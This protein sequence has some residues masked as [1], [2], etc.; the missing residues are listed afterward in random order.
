MR[1]LPAAADH[2]RY[3]QPEV[4]SMFARLQTVASR[5]RTADRDQLVQQV[6]GMISGHPGFAGLAMLEREDGAGTMVTLWHTREDA[7]LASERSQAVRGPRPFTLSTDDIYEVDDDVPG[8]AA[9]EQAQAAFVGYFD[10]PL[11]PARVA[12]ARRGGRDRIRPALQQVPGLIRTLVLWHPSDSKMAVVHLVSSV[13]GLQDLATAIN[14]TRLLPDEDPS[15]L[16]GPD[17]VETHRVLSYLTP[18]TRTSA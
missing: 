12:A 8:T 9:G 5:P 11:S 13:D 4:T 15:L 14:S 7:E 3:Q 18:A 6:V 1:R 10:G 16:T 17:R 2:R